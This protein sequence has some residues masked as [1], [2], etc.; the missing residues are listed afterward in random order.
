MVTKLYGMAVTAALMATG[1]SAQ[2]AR[3]DKLKAELATLRPAGQTVKGAPYSADEISESTQVLGDGTRIH[4][5]TRGK[6]YRDSEGRTRRESGD[7]ATI[8]D[9]VAGTSYKLNTKTMTVEK[10]MTMR[11]GSFSVSSDSSQSVHVSGTP[12]NVNVSNGVITINRNGQVSTIPVPADGNWNSPD[13]TIHVMTRESMST[14]S[15]GSATFGVKDGTITVTTKDGHTTTLPMPQ[16][17]ASMARIDGVQGYAFETGGD[18]Q[19]LGK[20]TVEGVLSDGTR[21]TTHL[22]AG[23]VGNDR[24]IDIVNERWYSSELQV[25]ISNHH[26]DPR[27][28]E[29]SHRLTNINRGEPPAYLFQVPASY[30]QP[31]RKM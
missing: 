10:L 5:E 19:S 25:E 16:G 27:T 26:S 17:G 14:G 1:A 6:I 9:P 8:I 22:N 3:I 13:G 21:R 20:Q 28:G 7:T 15:N 31:E 4:N 11:S 23:A 18:A 24:P 12:A 29:T 30:N 2:D